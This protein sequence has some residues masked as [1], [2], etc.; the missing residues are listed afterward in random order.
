MRLMCNDSEDYNKR[1][2][3]VQMAENNS[4]FLQHL[5]HNC[6]SANEISYKYGLSRAEQYMLFGNKGNKL[7]F[8]K[9]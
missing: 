7:Q 1:G 2:K 8:C 4:T 3:W 9:L 6:M 5:K